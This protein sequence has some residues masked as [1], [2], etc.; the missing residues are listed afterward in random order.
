[1]ILKNKFI[2]LINYQPDIAKIYLCTKDPY[3]TKYQLLINKRKITGL[4]HFNDSKAFFEYSNYMDGIYK[5][6]EEYNPN[7]KNKIL[8]IFDDVI[9][10]ML[11]NKILNPIVYQII[12]HR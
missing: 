2:N 6:I 11:S 1:M 12:Y 8:I 4:K 7:K 5:N 9:A 10:D 3:E